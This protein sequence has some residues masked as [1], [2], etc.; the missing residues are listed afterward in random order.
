MPTMKRNENIRKNDLAS[1]G[2][3][4]MKN[5]VKT[6]QMFEKLNGGARTHT[7]TAW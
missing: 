1:N 3:M 7:Q 4:L 5:F 6:G 2:I